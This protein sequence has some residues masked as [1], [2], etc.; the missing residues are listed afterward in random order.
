MN[1][2]VVPGGHIQNLY[3][4]F[5]NNNFVIHSHLAPYAHGIFPLASRLF[6]HSCAPN[7]APKFI[8]SPARRVSMEVVS[9]ASIHQ[10]EEVRFDVQPFREF[11]D[12]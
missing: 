8:I 11:R 5:A 10:D 3:A 2:T 6:N 9:L 12:S 1:K 7:A 4:R